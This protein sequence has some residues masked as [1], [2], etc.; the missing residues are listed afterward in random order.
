M[1]SLFSPGLHRLWMSLSRGNRYFLFHTSIWKTRARESYSNQRG[2]S[3]VENQGRG[4]LQLW[5]CTFYPLDSSCK[6]FITRCFQFHIVGRVVEPKLRI[7]SLRPSKLLD[8]LQ[9]LWH[10][11]QVYCLNRQESNSKCH[12]T[13][14]SLHLR[15]NT[16][17][18]LAGDGSVGWIAG[19]KH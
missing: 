6:G 16:A 3:C 11:R 12:P 15:Y 10:R 7:S 19:E 18:V 2:P 9:R 14:W 8:T 17:K 5:V 4:P 13:E 1:R